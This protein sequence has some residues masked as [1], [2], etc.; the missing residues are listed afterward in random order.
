M[1]FSVSMPNRVNVQHLAYGIT[2]LVVGTCAGVGLGSSYGRAVGKVTYEVMKALQDAG[3][4][5]GMSKMLPEDEA[6]L[7]NFESIVFGLAG[8]VAGAG[9]G[10]FLSKTM[11]ESVHA[12]FGGSTEARR[13]QAQFM[14]FK[15]NI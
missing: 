6:K 3:Y 8:I 10:V 1:S 4:L 11:G 14:E 15:K 7:M 12:F 5:N 13:A 9:T 2:G